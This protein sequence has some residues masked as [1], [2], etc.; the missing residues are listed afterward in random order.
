MADYIDIFLSITSSL[1]KIHWMVESL[2]WQ[3]NQTKFPNN[4]EINISQQ[5]II[6][7]KPNL[8]EFSWLSN[9]QLDYSFS[10]HQ[11]ETNGEDR[12]VLLQQYYSMHCRVFLFFFGGGG[13]VLAFEVWISYR[14]TLTKYGIVIRKHGVVMRKCTGNKLY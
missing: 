11:V 7:C 8:F 10:R 6:F 2:W 1:R 9:E 4:L 13:R 14:N 3:T 12:G 5:P